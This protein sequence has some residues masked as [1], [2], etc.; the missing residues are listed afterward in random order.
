ME[1]ARID[2]WMWAVRLFRTRSES[3]AACRGGHV[4]I[5]GRPA[6]PASPVEVGQTIEARAHGVDR[7]VVV[8]RVIE[9][10]VGASVAAECLIDHTPPPPPKDVTPPVAV[11]ERGAGRPTKRDRRDIDRLRRR[12][13]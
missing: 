6:K 13:S 3:A 10:R 11:R 12:G 4:R 9:K 2:R 1:T 7:T 8:A 5:D